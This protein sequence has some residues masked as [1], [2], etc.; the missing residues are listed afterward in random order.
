MDGTPVDRERPQGCP[1]PSRSGL[2]ACAWPTACALQMA[3]APSAPP[4]PLAPSALPTPSAAL[5]HSDLLTPSALSAPSAPPAP[6]ALRKP[7][8]PLTVPVRPTARALTARAPLTVLARP[9]ARAQSLSACAPLMGRPQR[10]VAIR[11]AVHGWP[12]AGWHEEHE[13]AGSSHPRSGGLSC[14]QAC[15][16]WRPAAK[17]YRASC[18]QLDGRPASTTATRQT[19]RRSRRFTHNR[20]AGLD[21]PLLTL[22]NDYSRSAQLP[23]EQRLSVPKK[24]PRPNVTRSCARTP[25]AGELDTWPARIAAHD[26]VKSGRISM[27]R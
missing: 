19:S 15:G 18:G 17:C 5:A 21:T 6:F 1:L 22:E 3:S 16:S 4:A 25:C 20:R 7:S 2:V 9:T 23:A 26:R 27:I 13:Y 11:A 8:A 10:Q 24:Q 12:V 14:G